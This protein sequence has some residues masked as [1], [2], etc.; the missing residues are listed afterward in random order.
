MQP[1]LDTRAL[2]PPERAEAI[3]SLVWGNV[4]RVEIDHHVPAPD[5]VVSLTLGNCGDLGVC[6]TRATATTVRRTPKLAREDTEPMVFLSLQRSGCSIVVQHGREAVLGPGDFAVYDTA[7]PYSLLFAAGI[8][9]TFFRLPRSALALPDNSVRDISAVRIGST[10]PLAGLTSQYLARLADDPV[11]LSGGY[12][13]AAATATIELIRAALTVQLGNDQLSRDPLGNSL[14]SRVLAD[15]RSHLADPEL[16]PAAV[17]S[18]HHISVRYLHRILQRENI[19]FG[20]WVRHNRLERA[21]RDLAVSG[22]S[23]TPVAVI[24]RRW[25]FTDAGHFSRA[26]RAAYGLSPRE[27]RSTHQQADAPASGPQRCDSCFLAGTGRLAIRRGTP[28]Q[29]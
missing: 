5:M 24:A 3:R 6:A 15:M 29:L 28:S 17:A 16:S 18:R 13:P 10:N 9:A 25:G 1:T 19:R 20:E 22:H 14:A 4:V 23:D 21:R 11:I 7:S 2:A 27:W 12:G 26:F 8:D